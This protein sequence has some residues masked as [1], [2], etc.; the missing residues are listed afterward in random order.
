M[1]GAVIRAAKRAVVKHAAAEW[2]QVIKVR[3]EAQET[4]AG[5]THW[6]LLL[7]KAKNVL[8]KAQCYYSILESQ[9]GST[10]AE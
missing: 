4:E 10:V 5:C 3:F 8:F 2:D 1:G 9:K 7:H 6:R